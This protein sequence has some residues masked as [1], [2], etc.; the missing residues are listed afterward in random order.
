VQ[1]AVDLAAEEGCHYFGLGQ[2]SSIVSFNGLLLKNKIPITTGN[3]LTAGMAVRAI[4]DLLTK[5]GASPSELR[6]GVVGFTGNICQVVSQLLG[7][8]GAP[9]TLIHREPYSESPRFQAAA[10]SLL[11]NSKVSA[12]SLICTHEITN[13][14]DC[15]IVLVGTNSSQQFI[16]QEHFK[17]NAIVLDISVPSNLHSS[18]RASKEI[19][20]FQGGFV[21]FPFEQV[22]EHHWIPAAGTKNWF[23]CMGETL[24]CGLNTINHSFSVGNLEKGAILETLRMADEMGVTLGDLRREL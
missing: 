24:L 10:E 5:R 16:M 9:M 14:R 17:K 15:D 3:S 21:R 4:E 11:K 8:L 2:Y 1:E 7:D 18:V 13:L 6:I 23:A 19:I 12:E 20:S 22:P